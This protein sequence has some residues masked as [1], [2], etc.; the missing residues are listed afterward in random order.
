VIDRSFSEA[1]LKPQ[2]DAGLVRRVWRAIARSD[3]QMGPQ[4]EQQATTRSGVVANS[5]DS[6]YDD[7]FKVALDR[8]GV[9]DDVDEMDDNSEETSVAL[10]TIADNA[11]SSEDGTM[12]SF[13][14][15][16][17]E[18]KVQEI[19][20]HT[21]DL[22]D[23]HRKAYLIARSGLKFGDVW[24]EIIVSDQDMQITDLRFLPPRSMFRNEDKSG[25]LRMADPRY[26]EDGRCQNAEGECA[27]EQHD[28]NTTGV[29]ATFYPWQIVHGRWNWN[30]T[31]PY[32]QSYLRVGRIIWKKLK[33]MEES[34]IIARLTRAFLK[35]VFYV[36]TS[37]LSMPE[38][39]LALKRFRDS[40]QRKSDLSGTRENAFSVFTDIYLSAENIRMGQ[41]IADSK[42]KVEAID[43]KNE[44]LNVVHDIE[45]LHRKL[46]AVLRVPPAYYGFEKDI[47]AKNTLGMQDIQFVRVLRRVQ[48]FVGLQLK[49]IFDT[50]LILEGIDPT[51]AEYDIKW[52]T[53]SVENEQNRANA[54]YRVAQAAALLLGTNAQNQTPVVSPEYVLKHMM[55][56][57]DDVVAEIMAQVEAKEEEDQAEKDQEQ[58]AQ[59]R[60][61]LALRGAQAA[62]AG[63]PPQP[64][65]A[66][67][68]PNE[69]RDRSTAQ[70]EP[71]GSLRAR[72]GSNTAVRQEAEAVARD[73]AQRLDEI[74]G[75]DFQRVAST[76]EESLTQAREL[77]DRLDRLVGN[78][79]GT[80]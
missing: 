52:P 70:P 13:V 46:L 74:L 21:T 34:L 56:L 31:S 80:G 40:M 18:A 62:A 78:G 43:P 47:N 8:L 59:Q 64:V 41:Q 39:E 2:R 11:T 42:T 35:L 29:A 53:L 65:Q 30:G 38:K 6:L 5:S 69:S 63:E 50:Q 72:Q 54:I 48:A 76:Q 24:A 77:S 28:V 26:G 33:A 71:P 36:D 55:E 79:H 51:T 61:A 68:G 7:I 49:Q 16:A 20:D 37:G 66:P 12:T 17:K 45:H 25:Y 3:P 57:D 10:D 27:F 4:P 15:K 22:C 19:L 32:G 9:Y 14:V 58:Q 44:G 1:A 73:L 23:L 67:R 75:P 60:A